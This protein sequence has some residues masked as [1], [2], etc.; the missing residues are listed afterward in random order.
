MNETMWNNRL[1]E[2]RSTD[3][4][5]VFFLSTLPAEPTERRLALA[6]VLASS[7]IFLATVPLAK[8]PLTPIFAFIPIYQST[9]AINDLIT[10]VLLFGQFA[11]LRSPGL[12]LLASGYLFTAVMAFSHML[13]FPGCLRRPAC[14]APGP[15]VRPGCTCSGMAGSPSA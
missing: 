8:V 1:G 3:G 15:R 13:T 10:A 11:F 14:W 12:L 7:A 5:R 9:L 4:H 2:P 6:V